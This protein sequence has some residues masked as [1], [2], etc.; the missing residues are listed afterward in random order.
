MIIVPPNENDLFENEPYQLNIGQLLKNHRQKNNYEIK[1]IALYL[2][3]KEEDL[4]MLEN[5]DI[6]KI[7]KNIYI[8]GLIKTYGKFL[9]IN[10]NL[11]EEKLL[12]INLRSNIEI[13]KHTLLNIGENN[14]LA[15]TKNTLIKSSMIFIFIFLTSLI[16][17][18]NSKNNQ[19]IINTRSIMMEINN[20]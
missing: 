19:N 15:P 1:D 14:E 9:K 5:N 18:F 8:H 6:D 17:F 13:K 4:L 16:I 10:S 12:E 7:A 3:V 20:N 11:I 2:R